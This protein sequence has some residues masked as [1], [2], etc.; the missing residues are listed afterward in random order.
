MH[1]GCEKCNRR[2]KEFNKQLFRLPCDIEHPDECL[3]GILYPFSAYQD[4]V[5]MIKP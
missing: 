3:C 2:I 4:N 5:E 1:S